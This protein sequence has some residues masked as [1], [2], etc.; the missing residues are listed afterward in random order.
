MR[1]K[2]IK[3]ILIISVIGL[4]AL[5]IFFLFLIPYLP[6]L[7]QYKY[8]DYF[9]AIR[10]GD[11]ITYYSMA[12]MIYKFDFKEDATM[13]GFPLMIV[14]FILIFGN[15]FS[16]IFFPLIIFNGVVLFSLTLI[17]IVWS[18]FLIFKKVFPA[19][20]SGFLFLIFPFIFYLFR[21][22]GPQFQAGA[23]NDI[24]FMNMNWLSAMADGPAAFFALLV[25]FLSLIAERKRFGMFF[26][27]LLGF[28][29]G[30]SAM[31]RIT[32]VVIILA[33]ALVILSPAFLRGKPR[34][35]DLNNARL[36]F[37][38]ATWF[39][40]KA[41]GLLSY[42]L[43][44]IIGFLPQFVYNTVFFGSPFSFGYQKEYRVDWVAAGSAKGPA[45][46]LDSFF[47][48]FSRAADYSL[49]FIPAFLFIFGLALLGFLY[50]KKLNKRHAFIAAL[51]FLPPTF[52]YMFFETGQTAMRYYMPAVPAFVILSV[53]ALCVMFDWLKVKFFRDQIN[54]GN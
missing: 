53:A 35:K 18:S 8:N 25:L 24:N 34:R 15:D 7:E 14:P 10:E 40:G 32:N 9:S 21:N 4:I 38:Q 33:A 20:L 42:F 45:W 46:S 26:Y 2:K 3:N 36:S 47:H 50:I 13:F 19:I 43:S 29:A 44:S 23:W 16:A 17:L 30:F 49:L 5:R 22:Y 1:D 41:G 51:W 39:S 37:Q 12:G 31:V 11:E 27:S 28:V 52:I 48:L 54:Q 6:H